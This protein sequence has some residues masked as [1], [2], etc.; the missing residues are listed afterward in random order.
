MGVRHSTVSIPSAAIWSRAVSQP[1][2]RPGIPV[3]YT[4]PVTPGGRGRD[5]ICD[6][7]YPFIA[8]Q[9]TIAPA[10]NMPAMLSNV[11][12]VKSLIRLTNAVAR[13]LDRIQSGVL[14]SHLNH[15]VVMNNAFSKGGNRKWV[16]GASGGLH[17]RP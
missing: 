10:M 9:L 4:R 14:N 15:A 16:V 17:Q 6:M 12:A 13:E 8:D 3:R 11:A 2:V 7:V 5:R 1:S